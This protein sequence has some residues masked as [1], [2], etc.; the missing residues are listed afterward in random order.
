MLLGHLLLTEEVATAEPNNN[1][2]ISPPCVLCVNSLLAFAFSHRN[3]NSF[4]ASGYAV[5]MVS[6]QVFPNMVRST[7]PVN[8]LWTPNLPITSAMA[9]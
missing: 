6:W 5:L 3:C 4:G 7:G 2:L 8:K 9:L 1:R